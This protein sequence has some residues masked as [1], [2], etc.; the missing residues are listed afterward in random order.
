MLKLLQVWRMSSVLCGGWLLGNHIWIFC[1]SDM[2]PT[3]FPSLPPPYHLPLLIT[4]ILVNSTTVFFTFKLQ[5]SIIFPSLSLP[6]F[7]CIAL[8]FSSVLCISHPFSA[9]LP[10]SHPWVGPHN[11]YQDHSSLKSLV[12]ATSKQKFCPRCMF[13]HQHPIPWQSYKISFN[14]YLDE[15]NEAKID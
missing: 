12:S 8:L 1:V 5:I 3:Y 15:E 4:S 10:Q 7:S 9:F 13:S 6:V 11:P 2:S 14:S